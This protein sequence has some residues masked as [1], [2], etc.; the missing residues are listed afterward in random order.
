MFDGLSIKKREKI[1]FISFSF[2]IL[3]TYIFVIGEYFYNLLN[4]KV[5]EFNWVL[6]KKEER[7]IKG[8]IYPC[9]KKSEAWIDYVDD[10]ALHRMKIKTTENEKKNFKILLSHSYVELKQNDT[11]EKA[12][13][14]LNK[15]NDN[16]EDYL[17]ILNRMK[18]IPF[19]F[20][21]ILPSTEENY[22]LIHFI[23]TKNK[24]QE[25]DYLSIL[26]LNF[27]LEKAKCISTY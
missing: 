15:I 24:I 5:R 17:L 19:E 11:Y 23:N 22:D 20:N 25:K 1:F 16:Y 7:Y 14:V 3:R 21:M 12:A 9:F 26:S 8:I 10:H 13:L 18:D 4:S 27:I 2:L 6:S